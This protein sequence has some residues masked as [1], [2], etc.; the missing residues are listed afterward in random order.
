MTSPVAAPNGSVPAQAFQEIGSSGLVQFGG[1]ITDDELADWR[2]PRKIK[3]IR[4]M[5]LNDATIGGLLFAIKMLIRQVDWRVDAGAE[6][7]TS[8][9]AAELVR[10]ALFDDMSMTWKDTLSD[11][12]SFLPWGWEFSEVVYKY[13]DG[14]SRDPTRRSKYTDGRIGWRKWPIRS[15]ETLANWEFDDAGGIRGMTQY[16][17]PSY[18]T[19][20][21]PLDPKGLLFRTESN[22]NNPEGL[23]I[24]RTAY[25]PWRMKTRLENIEGLGLERDV[26]G[27][28][29]ALIP[30][31]YM[32]PNAS[33]EM[34]AV[35]TLVK[36]IVANIRND[37]GGGVVFPS[38]VDESSGKSLFEL[39]LL[40]TAGARQFNTD[41]IINRYDQRILMSVLA[42][43]MMLGAEKVGSFALAESDTDLFAVAIGAW[44]ENISSV[45]NRFA[46]PRLLAAN[47]MRPE[48]MPYLTHADIE[49]PDLRELGDYISKMMTVGAL[50]Y[51]T[52]LEAFARRIASLPAL[53]DEE[54]QGQGQQ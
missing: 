47:A 22:R 52:G 10:T 17:L 54:Q 1:I 49:L 7:N 28:P 53:P 35:Y 37:E 16:L 14:T 26:A 41:A 42:D 4:S 2:S 21:I 18:T 30:S 5:M 43:F 40:S 45:V 36:K 31:A 23:S 24:L 46:I 11:I 38:D 51:D 34:Q 29:V 12:V 15:Q 8:M 48:R 27:L 33:A 25:R 20:T 19:A 44:L 9:E 6:D 13:R 50:T 39:K 32:D 3:T